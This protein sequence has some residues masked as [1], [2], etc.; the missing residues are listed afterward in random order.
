MVPIGEQIN[1]CKFS[2]ILVRLK[3]K[4]HQLK[5]LSVLYAVK[6]VML[7]SNTRGMLRVISTSYGGYRENT[8]W[9]G[10]AE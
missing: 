1:T 8:Q 4:L 10:M 9:G 7:R 5:T 6:I 3:Y 2:S